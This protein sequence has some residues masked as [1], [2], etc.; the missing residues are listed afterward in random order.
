VY[1]H[2]VKAMTV[3]RGAAAARVGVGVA[4]VFGAEP[5]LRT[6][7]RDK[8]PSASFVLFARTLGVRDA[9]FGLGG[10]LSTFDGTRG[11]G[12][13]RWVQ[14]WL[15]NEVVDVVIAVTASRK[16]G[17]FGA[18]TAALTPLPLVAVDVWTLR[19]LSDARNDSE[20][21]ARTLTD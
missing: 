1:G 9:I 5:V 13:R 20:E 4:L 14:L 17:A 10:L 21:S 18:A 7:L 6:T 12:T 19:H 11:G 15:A 16:L 3:V 8:S 2:A